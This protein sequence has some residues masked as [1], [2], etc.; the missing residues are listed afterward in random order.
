MEKN[1]RLKK[2]IEYMNNLINLSIHKAAMTVGISFIISVIVVTLVDDFLLAN[3]VVPGDTEVL[4]N[5]I[6]SNEGFFGF[7]VVG[8]L[9]VLVLDSIIGLALYV[10]LQPVSKNLALLTSGLR[11][12]YAFVLTIGV[13]ALALQMTD[14]YG[15]RSI[16][17]F[18]YILFAMH[19]FVLGYS[20][21]RSGY[22]PKSLGLFLM[23]ASFT[24]ISFFVDFDLTE[25]LN[26]FIM[27]IM[28]LAE[29]SLSIWLIIKRNELPKII[30]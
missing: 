15:Y 28:A 4:A 3:F 21:F 26:V 30:N 2:T 23:I 10:V 25:A 22:I 27:I 13:I 7:A 6:E 19:L 17:L 16:K 11:L 9:I 24:Y 1:E 18:G 12:L 8:Y 5:D 14:V 29:L 20:V